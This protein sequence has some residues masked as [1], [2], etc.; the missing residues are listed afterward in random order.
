MSDDA[1]TCSSSA[2]PSRPS[3]HRRRLPEPI[4]MT[5]LQTLI[6]QLRPSL[7]GYQWTG[8]PAGSEGSPCS[9]M[10]VFTYGYYGLSS[11]DFSVGYSLLLSSVILAFKLSQLWPADTPSCVLVTCAHCLFETPLLLALQDAPS[12]SRT[13][14]ASAC[15]VPSSKDRGFFSRAWHR[16]PRSAGWP[17]PRHGVSWLLPPPFS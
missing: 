6:C 3:S 10:R 14:P 2:S 9:P 1:N 4:F 13:C 11:S 16:G 12:S 17:G 8:H 5:W 7:Q 15:T